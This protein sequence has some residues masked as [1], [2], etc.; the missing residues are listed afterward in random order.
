MT[1]PY[2]VRLK[3]NDL[4]MLEGVYAHLFDQVKLDRSDDV[5]VEAKEYYDH[6]MADV[7]VARKYEAEEEYR[8]SMDRLFLFKNKLDALI[9]ERR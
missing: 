7:R 4:N 2:G 8:E 5:L 1:E 3:M 6:V 9:Q